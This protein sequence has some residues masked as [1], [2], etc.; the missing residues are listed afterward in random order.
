MCFGFLFSFVLMEYLKHG[1]Q[2]NNMCVPTSQPFLLWLFFL[3]ERNL[4]SSVETHA[5][6]LNAL[7]FLCSAIM[8]LMDIYISN[9]LLLQ[10]SAAES[11]IVFVFI[12]KSFSIVTYLEV[13]LLSQGVSHLLL[14]QILPNCFPRWLYQFIFL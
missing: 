3:K 10:N 2:K 12:C 8:L 13:E 5:L 6:W 11:K 4:C 9:Y 7:L 1:K 14:C